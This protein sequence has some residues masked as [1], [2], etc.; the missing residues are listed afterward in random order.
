MTRALRFI[1]INRTITATPKQHVI[2]PGMQVFNIS[3]DT[4]V[5]GFRVGPRYSF[6][7][8]RSH[9]FDLPLSI[10]TLN[11]SNNHL[12]AMADFL[13]N[14]SL[15]KVRTV[16]LSNCQI[17][18]GQDISSVLNVLPPYLRQLDFCANRIAEHFNKVVASGFSSLPRTLDVL[19]FRATNLHLLAVENLILLF[20]NLPALT[21]LDLSEINFCKFSPQELVAIFS[22]L[23]PIAELRLQKCFRGEGSTEKMMSVISA[24][25]ASTHSLD[26]GLNDLYTQK[27]IHILQEL[28]SHIRTLKLPNNNLNLIVPHDLEEAFRHLKYICDLD[29][30]CNNLEDLSSIAS[31]PHVLS[32]NLSQNPSA[33]EQ[34]T[35]Y[36]P[37]SVRELDWSRNEIT[38]S[39]LQSIPVNVETLIL[40]NVSVTEWEQFISLLPKTLKALDISKNHLWGYELHARSMED[41][42]SMRNPIYTRLPF[43]NLPPTLEVL[44]LGGNELWRNPHFHED[45]SKLAVALRVLDL[46][47]N[48][49]GR[50][51]DASVIQLCSSIGAQIKT[52]SLE[53]NSLFT[54][55]TQAEALS[56]YCNLQTFSQ[57]RQLGLKKNGFDSTSY[58]L[59]L[60]MLK[61]ITGMEGSNGNQKYRLDSSV[62]RN[63]VSFLFPGKVEN[64]LAKNVPG[65]VGHLSRFDYLEMLQAHQG[66]G[67]LIW[68]YKAFE[69]VPVAKCG[70]LLSPSE[71][72]I[73]SLLFQ[74]F[75][76]IESLKKFCDYA[77][78]LEELKKATLGWCIESYQKVDYI[79]A[80]NK[81]MARFEGF[82][83]T[84]L[85]NYPVIESACMQVRNLLT[86][87]V[88]SELDQQEI[89]VNHSL[90]ASSRDSFGFFSGV[91]VPAEEQREENPVYQGMQTP[92][93]R[94]SPE[95][96]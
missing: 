1:P 78:G 37:E 21:L 79:A 6:T 63:I 94:R 25:S 3:G 91:S 55:K 46:S 95:P 24:L 85:E 26:L 72:R 74:L 92:Q 19:S 20:N 39:S 9:L 28:P 41:F 45:I 89:L 87:L 52:V 66:I 13:K 64:Y 30:S 81:I 34:L 84:D 75:I 17:N 76:Q 2:E 77:D 71:H 32:L 44:R 86:S 59:P 12:S 57:K 70:G 93:R 40:H 27:I 65:I 36:L 31:L 14:K 62:V 60:F 90:F 7:P 33:F 50:L 10:N 67:E 80:I 23:P 53:N 47:D 43:A 29:L 5:G 96:Q 16:N 42:L 38:S 8:N 68:Y 48:E 49:F 73:I 69:D 83:T 88:E 54:R 22:A 18:R 51:T 56:L 35:S 61:C 11:L 15:T 4:P 58:L 82:F